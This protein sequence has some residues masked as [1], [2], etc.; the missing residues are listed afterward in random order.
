MMELEAL[1]T[2]LPQIRALGASLVA[3]SPQRSSYGR[4]VRRRASLEFDVLS[5]EGLKVAQA[6]GLAFTLPPY[7]Q[8][9]YRSF[10]NTLDTFHGEPA[11]RLPLRLPGTLSTGGGRFAPPTLMRTTR[12][13]LIQRRPSHSSAASR[14]T[15]D[16]ISWFRSSLRL[17][18]GPD[19]GA[20]RPAPVCSLPSASGERGASGARAT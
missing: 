14:H 11:Y 8:E 18:S 10:G 3:I 1:Q 7:L 9:L 19:I 17:D 2:V 15:R 4:A 5:D 16:V 6:F 12:F 20:H 13:A